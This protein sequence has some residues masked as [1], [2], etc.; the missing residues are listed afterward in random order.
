MGRFKVANFVFPGELMLG[1]S[2]KCSIAS[3]ICKRCKNVEGRRERKVREGGERRK[4]KGIN[5]CRNKVKMRLKAQVIPIKK[6]P[7]FKMS[8]AP[9]RSAKKVPTFTSLLLI[10]K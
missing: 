9:K 10:H 3:F 8:N 5:G 6:L 2:R 1:S 7:L 4:A